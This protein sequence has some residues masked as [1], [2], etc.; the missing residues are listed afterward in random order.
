MKVIKTII[1]V[2]AVL[3]GIVWFFQGINVIPD[4]AMSGE[5]RFVIAGIVAIVG[6]VVLIVD[7]WRQKA[8]LKGNP[9]TEED[10]TDDAEEKTG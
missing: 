3:I 2:V 7:S 9:A 8:D 1:G 5:T 4:S 6:G 10:K